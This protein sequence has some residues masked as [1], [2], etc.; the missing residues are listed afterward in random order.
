MVYCLV[1]IRY[2]NKKK[3]LPYVDYLGTFQNSPDNL[4]YYRKLSKDLSAKRWVACFL[5]GNELFYIPTLVL[6]SPIFSLSFLVY[7]LVVQT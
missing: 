1:S 5:P 2:R 3:E 6:C 4:L 7:V